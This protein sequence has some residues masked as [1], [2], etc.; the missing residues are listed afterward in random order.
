M[1]KLLLL[2]ALVGMVTMGCTD[3]PTT[4]D[5]NSSTE[6]P[7]P[8][9]PVGD[10]DLSFTDNTDTTPEISHEGGTARISF[11]TSLSWSVSVYADWLSVSEDE[12]EAGNGSF[13]IT[14]EANTTTRERKGVVAIK[15]SNNKSYEITV[16]Q[17]FNTDSDD[18]EFINNTNTAPRMEYGGGTVQISFIAKTDWTVT[19]Y[20]DW[21]STS[22]SSGEKGESSFF[23]T[24][25]SNPNDK[26]RSGVVAIKTSN[27]KSYE[28]KVT[29]DPN[30][31]IMQLT[32]AANE[33][34]YTTIFD[35]QLT[36]YKESGFGGNLISHSYDAAKGYGSIRFDNYVTSIP[37]QAFKDCTTLESIYLPE[38]VTYIA[39]DAF[40]G[41]T[42]LKYII[43]PNSDNYTMFV[44]NG[45]IMAVAPSVKE[46]V[47]PEGVQSVGNVVFD[48]SKVENIVFPKSMENI[49]YRAF[50]QHPTLQSVVLN[51]YTNIADYAFSGCYSLESVTYAVGNEYGRYQIGSHAFEKCSNLKTVLL[52]EGLA[53]LQTY[54]FSE[55]GLI[56]ITIP[57]ANIGEKAFSDCKSL[58]R[59]NFEEGTSY[60]GVSAFEDCKSLENIVLPKSVEEIRKSAFAYNTKLK[61]I[62]IP[63]SVTLIGESAFYGCTGELTIN[64]KQLI[65]K[66]Y[67]STSY[68][69]IGWL[70]GA[71]FSKLIIGDAIT[72]IGDYVFYALNKEGTL[73]DLVLGDN[74]SVL[75]RNALPS[76]TNIHI[77]NCIVKD[78]DSSGFGKYTNVYIS[79]LST[80]CQFDCGDDGMFAGNSS[81][82]YVNG[83]AVTELTIPQG[84]TSLNGY[85]FCGCGSLKKV[86]ISEGVTYIG[87]RAFERCYNLEYVDIASTVSHMYDGTFFWCDSIKE[88]YCRPTVPPSTT[89]GSHF[90]SSLTKLYVPRESVEA[91]KSASYWNRIADQITG[92]DF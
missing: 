62:N 11:T 15:L 22:E 33:V 21:L 50:Y 64:C 45:E 7:G 34:L 55:S 25:A 12:G 89:Y 65:E 85:A 41:C 78:C 35:T 77:G 79:D 42:N 90:T 44:Y 72:S 71:N 29:Q 20:A 39:P 60:I 58:Q 54:A 9:V 52:A 32:V 67:T 63:E 47:V 18:I 19:C 92:Y 57:G 73:T 1:K 86:I 6:Q 51:G 4:D 70:K 75:G 26:E 68:P 48:Y 2:L 76:A 80:Y 8:D 46:L 40:E 59:V 24:A 43:S 82:M 53:T 17:S 66:D 3:N 36:L 91:Y 5:Q 84:V 23:I 87:K 16:T 38:G 61:S 88:V 83:E 10:E 30:A 13:V 27:N 14:A 28:I 74:L 37:S 49:K 31:G 69:A 81:I 56:E